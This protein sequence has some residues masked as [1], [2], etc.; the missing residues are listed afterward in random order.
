M[1]RR[2]CVCVRVCRAGASQEALAAILADDFRKVG[3]GRC[4]VV[5]RCALGDGAARHRASSLAEGSG[6]GGQEEQRVRMVVVVP[7][8]SRYPAEAPLVGFLCEALLPKTCLEVTK[9]LLGEADRLVTT[10]LE[11]YEAPAP[12]LWELASWL[13]EELPRILHLVMPGVLLTPH[14]LDDAQ[15][16]PEPE[17]EPQLAVKTKYERTREREAAKSKAE[18]AERRR[19]QTALMDAGEQLLDDQL[20]P[21]WHYELLWADGSITRVQATEVSRSCADSTDVMRMID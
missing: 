15:P 16:E 9:R 6:G 4:E 3:R 11:D 7:P 19:A 18:Q 2:A 17:P 20:G 12:V 5:L 1:R 10:N 21:R 14:S 13:E 8:G